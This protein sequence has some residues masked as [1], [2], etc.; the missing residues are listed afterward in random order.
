MYCVV[1]LE[2]EMEVNVQRMFVALIVEGALLTTGLVACDSDKDDCNK[3]G[4]NA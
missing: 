2:V 4:H 3:S 1:N